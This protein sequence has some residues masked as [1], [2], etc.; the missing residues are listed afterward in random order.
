M[1]QNTQNQSN[2]LWV[3]LMVI[4]FISLLLLIPQVIIQGMISE[5]NSTSIA[6]DEE[7]T[8][9][10]GTERTLYGPVLFIP[11]HDGK[12]N[13]YIMP[14][15]FRAQATVNTQSLNRGMFDISVYDADVVLDGSFV[16]PKEL[17][18]AQRL[19]LN[20]NRAQILFTINDFRG[21]VDYP[22]FTYQGQKMELNAG[23][24]VLADYGALSCLVDVSNLVA[25]GSSTF[26]LRVPIKGS[27]CICVVPVGRNTSVEVKSNCT[28][29]SFSG[30]Y[31]PTNRNVTD[32]GFTA[33]WKVL[34]LNR[35]F[36]QVLDNQARLSAVGT[37]DISLK[38]PV[39]QYQKTTRTSKYAYLIILLTFAVVFLVEQR[40][41]TPIHPVQYGLVGIALVLFYVLLLS[42]SEHV[43]FGLSY[44][45]ASVMTIGLISAFIFMLTKHRS[46]MLAVCGLLA[47]LY[48]FIFV[49]MQ[50]ETYALLVGSIGVFVILA[51]AMYASQKIKWY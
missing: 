8:Q 43:A 32:S 37:I 41:R 13:A 9:K 34:A 12:H 3:K 7:V 27:D 15:D 46:A 40:R 26:Q 1:D 39:E 25:G 6:A 30:D 17:D 51:L 22:T 36:P 29:P 18:E 38:V 24:K 20:F 23:D 4:F 21:F 48:T 42:F 19:Q 44:L 16:L 2:K 11:S 10:W 33:N 49:L 47:T 31:L 5:R 50:M 14:E 28:T 45:I 35:D